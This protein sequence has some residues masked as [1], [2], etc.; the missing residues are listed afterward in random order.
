M[1]VARPLE[2]LT[3]SFTKIE[4]VSSKQAARDFRSG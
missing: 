4:V 3:L 1:R 2:T